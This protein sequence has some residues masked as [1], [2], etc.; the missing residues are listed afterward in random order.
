[1]DVSVLYKIPND[2]V[3]WE[4]SESSDNEEVDNDWEKEEN[5]TTIDNTVEHVYIMN[6][7]DDISEWSGVTSSIKRGEIGLTY[8]TRFPKV[9]HQKERFLESIKGKDTHNIIDLALRE[10]VLNIFK[11]AKSRG[12]NS[13]LILNDSARFHSNAKMLFSTGLNS[14]NRI[15]SNWKVIHL[16]AIQS[17]YNTSSDKNYYFP[18]IYTR[19]HYAFIIRDIINDGIQKLQSGISID[20]F[21]KPYNNN[22]ETLVLY[23]NI[24]LNTDNISQYGR[25]IEGY[26]IIS[27]PK[28]TPL[29]SVI[30]TAYNSA[31]YI[32]YSIQSIL[33]Q[34][35]TNFELIIVDDCSKD[36]TGKIIEELARKDPRIIYLKNKTNYGKYVS[37][38][39]GIKHSK[40]QY[41]TFQDSDDYSIRN[42]LQLQLKTIT[43]SNY[44]VCYG[45]YIN[46]E[47]KKHFCEITLFMRRDCIDYIGY[48]DSVRFGADTE[49]RGRLEL[50]KI[51][52]KILDNYVYS[53]LDRLMEGNNIGNPTSLTNHKRTGMN[54]KLRL[55]YRKSFECYHSLIKTK[56][57][58]RNRSYYMNFPL[59]ERPFQIL[60][61]DIYERNS[62]CVQ[63]NDT[64]KYIYKVKL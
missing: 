52:I 34:T 40:G 2:N 49:Y 60:V 22:K 25:D 20:D 35:Y 38:N 18:N 63:L 16:S 42:R 10:T 17:N 23:P 47:M 19:S 13:I 30:M 5:I 44:L 15:H 6:K 29:I 32:K 58:M 1:M 7:I 28:K 41:I 9:D 26:T 53:R 59:T 64:D 37:K 31:R 4:S 12:Y 21:L 61:N 3:I 11:D 54:S 27:R 33:S 46:K 56:K 43:N 39:I 57:G 8:Y 24:V 51:P 48:F 50:L 36:T 55:I 62:I 45:K 14:I